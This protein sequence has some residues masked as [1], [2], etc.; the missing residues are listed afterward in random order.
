M[1]PD[2]VVVHVVKGDSSDM[3]LNL[4][5]ERVCQ[6]SEAPHLHSH[7][8]VLPLH[9]ASADVLRVGI[10]KPDYLFRS[11]ADWR[12]VPFMC[13][14]RF[15]V[16]LNQLRVVHFVRKRINDGVQIDFVAITGKLDT[17]SK[18]FLK[19]LNELGGTSS[20]TLPNEPRAHQL[21][22]GVHRNPGPHVAADLCRSHLLG[23]V[24]LLGSDKGPNLIYLDALARKIHQRL[25]QVLGTRVAEIGQQ[26]HDCILGDSGHANRRTDRV[27]FNKGRN[28]LSLAGGI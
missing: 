6:S 19:V 1:N 2:K 16:I 24:L 26:P 21:R 5:G 4:L 22:I 12:T 17:M 7:G 11:V 13:L 10:A 20:V 23:D 9:I 8:K 18:A 14:W 3:I 15:S 27:A 28:N 25:V